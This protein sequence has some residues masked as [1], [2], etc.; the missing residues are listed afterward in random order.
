VCVATWKMREREREI[1]RERESS[2]RVATNHLEEMYRHSFYSSFN[3]SS[4]LTFFKVKY[5]ET[6]KQ[7]VSLPANTKDIR[8]QI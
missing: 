3:F 2:K 8:S 1:E 7:N 6:S 5:K 4:S